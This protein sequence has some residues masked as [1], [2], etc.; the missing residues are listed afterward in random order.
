M[1]S[2]F[3][4]TA[5][6]ITLTATAALGVPGPAGAELATHLARHGIEATART[7]K[8]GSRSLGEAT[9][10]EAVALG[11]NLLVKGAYARSR[12]R[13]VVFGGATTHVLE[14]ARL[15][16]LTSL[17]L[18]LLAAQESRVD[19][20]AVPKRQCL[21]RWE[22]VVGG[23]GEHGVE[24]R[25][26]L[27]HTPRRRLAG[28]A[29]VDEDG[30]TGLLAAGEGAAEIDPPGTFIGA[31]SEVTDVFA[32]FGSVGRNPVVACGNHRLLAA[33]YG[34]EFTVHDIAVVIAFRPIVNPVDIPVSEP[35]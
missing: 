12:L 18:C 27:D 11:A 13:Q 14:H 23:A 5:L 25:H 21:P 16:V 30:H 15:P 10:A 33:T 7:V 3:R 32:V 6:A 2:V 19:E 26:V 35:E 28:V 8:A 31:K 22:D 34:E 29:G 9:L 17:G 1:R 24:V 4:A 20:D